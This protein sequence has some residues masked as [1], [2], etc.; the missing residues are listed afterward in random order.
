MIDIKVFGHKVPDTDTIC[1]AVILTNYLNNKGYNAKAYKLGELNNETAYLFDLLNLEIPETITSLP[2]GTKVALV[3]HN[4]KSQTIDNIDELDI[5]YIVDHH[6]FSI[7]T[8]NPINIRAEKLGS[9]A[10][11]LYKMYKE[12][13]IEISKE[14]GTL[15]LAAIL[16]DTLLF[17]SATT[18]KEDTIIAEELKSIT[19]INDFK[20]FMN[21]LFEA[22]SNLG[23]IN[24]I[25][26]IKYDYKETE[27]AGKMIGVGTIETVN[28][29]YALGRKEEILKGLEQIKKDGNL[30][31]IML[32]VVDIFGEKN[33]TIVLNGKDSEIVEKVFDTKIENNLADLKNRLSRKKQVVPNLT[34]YFNNL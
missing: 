1:S 19:G 16:S 27:I 33:I 3:D 13:N 11:V 26:L 9:T 6:K 12:S 20:E 5:E 2:S 14:I 4:E 28:P 18:T 29:S 30:E 8:S 21:P 31:F 34:E 25:D 23:D 24:V 15:M 17:R 22:K 10:S 32:S 7:T